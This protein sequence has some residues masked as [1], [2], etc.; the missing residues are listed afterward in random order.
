MFRKTAARRHFEER[1]RKERRNAIIDRVTPAKGFAIGA[2]T[3]FAT[4]LA[5]AYAVSAL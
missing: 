3:S 1:L 5:L 4:F 2:S